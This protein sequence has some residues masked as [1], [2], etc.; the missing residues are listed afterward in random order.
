MRICKV[1]EQ[2]KLEVD[3]TKQQWSKKEHL[4]VTCRV[5]QKGLRDGKKATAKALGDKPS[6]VPKKDANKVPRKVEA[7]LEEKR[8][9]RIKQLLNHFPSYLD[10]VYQHINL[11]RMT[12]LQERLANIMNGDD[13]R[14]ILEAARGTGKSYIGAIYATWRLLRDFDEKILVVSAAAPKAIEIA[15]FIRGLFD[16]VP[17]LKHLTPDKSM[18]C[19]DSVLAFDMRGCEMAIAPSCAVAG[20]SGQLTGRRATFILSDDVEVPANSA[21]ELQREQLLQKV[22][23]YESLLIPDKPSK[24]YFLGTPQSMESIYN[25]LPFRTVILPAMV[26]FNLEVYEGKLDPWIL[27]QGPAGTAT[28]NVRFPIEVLNVRKAGMG[29]ANFQLQFM[30]DT[31]LTDANRFPLKFKDLIV[32]SLKKDK[33]PLSVHYS[34]AVSNEINDIANVGFTGDRFH[35]PL[36][37]DPESATYDKIIMS[38][39]PAGSGTDEITY[40]ILGVLSGNVY[41]IDWGGSHDGFSDK[42]LLNLA[43]KAKE[44]SVQEI[45]PEKNWG[46][47]MFTE[48]FRKVLNA[49][50]PCTVIDDFNVTG[51]KELRIINNIEPLL[52]NHQIIINEDKIREEMRWV[53]EDPAERLQYSLM[54]QFSHITKDKQSLVH[55]DRLDALAIAV[56]YIKDMVIVDADKVLADMK[57]RQEQEII[58]SMI[59]GTYGPDTDIVYGNVKRVSML[60]S[61]YRG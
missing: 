42:S 23:E 26:P 7:T 12:P 16:R 32:M 13:E 40:T 21:T 22:Q 41:V 28:D 6:K 5:C 54:Y 39:D 37:I 60:N 20:I 31:S 48:M 30:L 9:E 3:Y 1:C 53:D 47:G 24:V 59:D 43:M 50:Y 18:G 33:A 11:P 34:G 38:I 52:T 36:G 44:Y 10:Y 61:M 29:N 45:V 58:D 46:G 2:E 15:T 27:E 19:R 35:S 49:V 51:Q 17:M 56:Q 55:D 57:A 4:T 25:K 14:L 8:Q